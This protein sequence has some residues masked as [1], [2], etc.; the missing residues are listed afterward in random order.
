MRKFCKIMMIFWAMMLIISII[1]VTWNPS[2][3]GFIFAGIWFG[4]L[5]VML[6]D[7]PYIGRLE[8]LILKMFKFEERLIKLLHRIKTEKPKRKNER[9][10]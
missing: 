2:D 10:K 3:G 8:K 5:L 7:F 6:I 4:G 9:K 1:Q